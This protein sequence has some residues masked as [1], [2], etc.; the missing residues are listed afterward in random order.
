MI[1]AYVPR[2]RFRQIYTLSI[3]TQRIIL[4]APTELLHAITYY[5]LTRAARYQLENSLLERHVYENVPWRIPHLSGFPDTI[6]DNSLPEWHTNS[7]II[8]STT[9]TN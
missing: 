5:L 6:P 3:R 7:D 1:Y 9:S 2:E 8:M 4:R